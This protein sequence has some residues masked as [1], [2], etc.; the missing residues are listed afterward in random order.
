MKIELRRGG[1]TAVADTM[2]GELVSFRDEQGTE[3]IWGGD[4]EIWAGRNPNLFPVVGNLMDGRVAVEGKTYEMARHG[5]ARRIEFA[6][7]EQGL[8]RIPRC[9]CRR[10]SLGSSRG[11]PAP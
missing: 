6:V 3:Y 1:C 2:G 10:S 4:P 7:A 11:S 9:R 5:F 8:S